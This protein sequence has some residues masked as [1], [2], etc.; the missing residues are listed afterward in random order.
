[1]P[2]SGDRGVYQ[3]RENLTGRAEEAK[4]WEKRRKSMEVED[5]R[6]IGE[7]EQRS[8]KRLK[9]LRGWSRR[10]GREGIEGRRG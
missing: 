5:D 8:N 10:G 1:M 7:K 4:R 6:K 3:G 9:K 2:Q